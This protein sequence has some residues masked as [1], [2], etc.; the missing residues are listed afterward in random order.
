MVKKYLKL[1]SEHYLGIGPQ[2]YINNHVK[3]QKF[4]TN[5]FISITLPERVLCTPTTVNSGKVGKCRVPSTHEGS[6]F[7]IY[8]YFL[9]TQS[10]QKWDVGI[11][12]AY[13]VLL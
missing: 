6:F 2:N 12:P 11:H 9:Q 8:V 5:K 10:V 1:F 13:L 3:K 7:C 4:T